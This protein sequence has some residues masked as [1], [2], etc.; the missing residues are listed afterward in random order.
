MALSNSRMAATGKGVGC[1]VLVVDDNLDNAESLSMF[2]RLLGHEVETAHDGLQAIEV[3]QRFGP[4]LVLLD[5]GL[6]KLDGYEVAQRLRAEGTCKAACLVAIT[7]WGRDE[8]SERAKD[9]GFDHHLTKPVDPAVLE[10]L[11]AEMCAAR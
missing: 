8:D 2:V 11:I 7:G 6:P 5:I 10:K 3:A 1:R 4:D 9:A